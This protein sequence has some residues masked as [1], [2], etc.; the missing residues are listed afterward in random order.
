[1]EC[2]RCFAPLLLI[3]A[4]LANTGCTLRTYDESDKSTRYFIIG[5]GTVKLSHE[6]SMQASRLLSVGA[7]VKQDA[8]PMAAVGLVSENLVTMANHTVGEISLRSLGGRSFIK[9]SSVSDTACV[10]PSIDIEL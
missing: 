1:M 6:E 7:V 4:L 3:V 8:N 5:F 9:L 2:F 10:N